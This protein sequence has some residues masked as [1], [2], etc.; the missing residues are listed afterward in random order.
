MPIGR[1][2]QYVHAGIQ[3]AMK[4]MTIDEDLIVLTSNATKTEIFKN[5]A[6]WNS[7]KNH[8]EKEGDLLFSAPMPKDFVV[9][10][11][12]ID[13]RTPNS[14]LAILME[15]GRT[16]KQPNPLHAAM[17]EVMQLHDVVN[18]VSLAIEINMVS[19]FIK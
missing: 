14:G 13:G 5:F 18:T 11:L 19:S 15:D 6:S 17:Q 2:A 12:T 9:S 8:C 7:Q 1:N 16:I 10:S 4:G 3:R